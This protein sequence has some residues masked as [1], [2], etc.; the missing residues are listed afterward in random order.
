RATKLNMPADGPDS[1]V[2]LTGALTAVLLDQDRVFYYHGKLDE[3]VKSGA[4]GTTNFDL[5]NGLGQVIREKQAWL[6]R[7]K[8][9][10]SK[11]LVL[12]IKPLDEAAY[13]NVVDVL[14]EV[15]INAV[16]TYVLMEIDPTEKEIIQHLRK[17][18]PEKNP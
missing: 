18:H 15:A 10:G 17:D 7:Q 6:N 8:E 13:K 4:Y 5:T 9:K 14:D 11:D 1:K 3:A 12:M 16:P 2:P